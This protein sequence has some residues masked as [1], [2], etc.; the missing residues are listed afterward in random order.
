MYLRHTTVTKNDKTHTYWR[1]VR[2]V[3][4]GRKVRQ[5]TVAQLGELDARG[6]VKGRGLARSLGG[7]RVAGAAA[8]AGFGFGPVAG[9]AAAGGAGSG[10][11]VGDG[12]GVG[13]R[14]AV[15]A[16]ER[17]AHRRG[18]VSPHGALG[19]AGSGGSEGQRRP[20]VPGVGPAL[21]AQGCVGAAPAGAAG[22]AVSA[23]G[24]PAGLRPDAPRHL[25]AR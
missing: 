16:L 21:A 9:A 12:R 22:D 20:S 14:S 8:V 4:S 3:R 10:A 5:E 11:V 15:R 25:G 24:R 13:D 23:G 1:L 2:S 18:L 19:F 6:R 17:A 7:G